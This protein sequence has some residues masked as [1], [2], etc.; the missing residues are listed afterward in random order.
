MVIIGTVLA[1]VIFLVGLAVV[2]TIFVR[3][4]VSILLGR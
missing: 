3:G 1:F 4:V 2:G